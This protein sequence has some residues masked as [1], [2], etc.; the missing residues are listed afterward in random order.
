MTD[1]GASNMRTNNKNAEMQLRAISE[2]A[3]AIATNA[4]NK[5]VRNWRSDLTYMDAHVDDETGELKVNVETFKHCLDRDAGY[6]WRDWLQKE[7]EAIGFSAED[8]VEG[9]GDCVIIY[10]YTITEMF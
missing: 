6:R 2:K 3:I 1:N 8:D 10:T 7:V 4:R 9:D 5:D